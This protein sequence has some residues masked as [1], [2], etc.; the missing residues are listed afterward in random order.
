MSSR[1]KILQLVKQ[2]Q[3]DLLAQPQPYDTCLQDASLQKFSSILESIG[4]AIF[5]INHL[6]DVAPK[7]QS[8]FPQARQIIST[9]A[10][11]QQY[12]SPFAADK[13]GQS[14][15]TIEVAIME[16][17]F[18]VAENGAVWVTEAESMYRVL[19]FIAEHLVVVMQQSKLVA[20]MHHAYE[21]LATADYTFGAFIAGPSK[22]ADIEQS[23]VLGA[24]GPK[25]MTVLIVP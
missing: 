19:P 23:L 10:G 13:I 14:F 12:F 25:T 20:T 22:T 3:P 9:L 7:V 17:A 4:G 16:A 11:V 8:I 6:D 24:H 2:N 15:D 5:T 21:L 18:G 1:D